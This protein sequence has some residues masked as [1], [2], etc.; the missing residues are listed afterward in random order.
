MNHKNDSSYNNNSFIIDGYNDVIDSEILAEEMVISPKEISKK[1]IHN[2]IN[3]SEISSLGMKV[4]NM[5][6]FHILY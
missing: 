3:T 6:Q 2:N 5:V 1:I 4:M